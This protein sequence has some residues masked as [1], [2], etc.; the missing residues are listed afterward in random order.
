MTVVPI[1]VGHPRDQRVARDAGVV[2]Q[3]VQLAA[4]FDHRVDDLLHAGRV[5]HVAG[6]DLGRA[7]GGADR[8][9]RLGQLVD[10]ASDAGHVGAGA[11]QRQRDR[12]SDAA[13]GAG[14]NR[15]VALQIDLQVGRGMIRHGDAEFPKV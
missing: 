12:A 4:L 3:D 2:D 6:I 13:R 10:A 11:G 14:D 7:A 5:G 15:G 1:L 9:G 8:V